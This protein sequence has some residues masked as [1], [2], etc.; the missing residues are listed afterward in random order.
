MSGPDT[1]SR[2]AA[3]LSAKPEAE[4]PARLAGA[5]LTPELAPELAV[6]GIGVIS[7]RGDDASAASL[8]DGP[9]PSD[10]WFDHRTELGRRGY[11]YLPAASQY[12]LAACNRALRASGGCEHVP[13]EERGA[14]VGTNSG[15]EALHSAMDETIVKTGAEDL[16]PATAPF[17]SINLFGSRTAME[18]AFKGF[19]LTLTSPRTAGLE[20][21][22]TGLRSLRL[23]R[24]SWLL[25][26]ATEDALAVLD[27]GA[28]R[29]EAGAVAM[30]LEPAAAA[31]AR[32]ATPLG[33]ISV[34]TGFLPPQKAGRPGGAGH[35][36]RLLGPVLGAGTADGADDA[37]RPEEVT[38]VL[39]DSPVGRA[40]AEALGGTA[41]RVPAGSGCLE[42]LLQTAG[43]LA[44]GGARSAAVV[45][46]AA[47]GEVAVCRISP[48]PPGGTARPGQGAPDGRRS[49]GRHSDDQA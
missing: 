37:A 16:S 27:P 21:L 49:A 11:K 32:G 22:R 3:R 47:T 8:P 38:A 39:D 20:A 1:T 35:A 10:G 36:R 9:V 33:G 6:T 4:P 30:V 46:A 24:A 25:A 40:V 26:G 17:F 45:T 23:G 12:F 28:S 19:N 43:A 15:A 2:A 29:S 42:P 18:H 31:T 48:A 34:R 5:Q 7:P 41:R 13:A 14:A 44:G